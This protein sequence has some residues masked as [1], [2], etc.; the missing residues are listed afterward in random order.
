MNCWCLFYMNCNIDICC[1]CMNIMIVNE[2]RINIF[3]NQQTSVIV[4]CSDTEKNCFQSHYSVPTPFYYTCANSFFFCSTLIFLSPLSCGTTTQIRRAESVIFHPVEQIQTSKT[5][6]IIS[7]DID[8]GPYSEA[9]ANIRN[10]STFVRNSIHIFSGSLRDVTDRRHQRLLNMTWHDVNNTADS[11]DQI[12]TNFV[13]L[14]KIMKSQTLNHKISKRSILPLQGI[15]SFL[16]GTVD[17]R[18]LDEVKRNVKILYDN[19]IK[20]G[21]VLDDTISITNISRALITENRHMI[22]SIIDSILILNDTLANIQKDIQPLFVTRRFLLTHA[23]VLVHSHRLRVAGSD[24]RNDI[25]KCGKYLDT[26]ISGKL[27][28]TLAD[29]IHLCNELLRIQKELPPTIELPE[30]P[31]NNI[32]H[33]YKYLTIF[34]T[35]CWQNNLVVQAIPSWFWF[36]YDSI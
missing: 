34:C 18:D 15:L 26:L 7:S 25:N 27:S 17:K 23:E 36:L 24:I 2:L 3:D 29:P 5:S 20:Q 33:Y 13:N 16:F 19:Q 22:N 6:W 11:L 10:Y 28:P 14:V 9:M 21:E 8:F 1:N 31:A 4:L 32:W 35:P 12:Y 30:N